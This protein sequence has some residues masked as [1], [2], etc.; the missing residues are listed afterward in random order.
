MAVK[1][2]GVNS[3]NAP[4]GVEIA[5][6]IARGEIT[7]E[8]VARQCLARIVGREPVVRAWAYLDPEQVLAQARAL[9]AGPRRGA[10]HGVPIG[11]KDVIDTFDM[12]TQMGSSIYAGYRPPSDAAC[13][14]AARAAGALIVGKTVT[15]EFAGLTP[16]PTTNPHDRERTPGG[17]SSGSAAA[18]ADLM[19]PLALGTQTG[20]SV[21]RPAS[22]CGVVGFKPSRAAINRAGVKPAAESLDTVGILARDLG[23]VDLLFA[24][25]TNGSP[26]LATGRRKPQRIGLCRTPMW[27][28]A[29]AETAH[30]V[31]D[32]AERLRKSG[33]GVEEI[34]LP[35]MFS[36]LIDVRSVINDYQRAH[37]MRF[38]WEHHRSQISPGLA[39]TIESGLTIS[40]ERVR[41]ALRLME[42]CRAALSA[43]FAEVDVL[44]AP[45]VDGEAPHGIGWTGDPVFQSL[46]TMLDTPSIG[47]PT[48][49]GPNA[50]PVSVQLVGAPF[51]DRELLQT[52]HW[53]AD[54]LTAPR[55]AWST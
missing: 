1:A 12:P 8:D 18:V 22:Y 51:A 15:A 52:A 9:D 37:A 4:G 32:G 35:P 46:W 47:L 27:S 54:H 24:A 14:A 16:G 3:I 19:V 5:A 6:R 48:H 7:C 10:L 23:D 40:A 45:C 11:V 33:V 25:L 28:R 13:V 53:A 38:E 21:L 30:A 34:T 55:L 26:A 44:L 41:A 49:T 50:L 2:V 29:Q 36:E 43:V 39:A 42:S 31:E 17:S 20:G